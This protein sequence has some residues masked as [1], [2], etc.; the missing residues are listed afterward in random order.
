M[1]VVLSVFPTDVLGQQVKAT[2]GQT[3]EIPSETVPNPIDG[4]SAKG[5]DA[6]VIG[7]DA[8]IATT[9]VSIVVSA[10]TGGRI[11]LDG[12]S[13]S[14]RKT[15]TG[16]SLVKAYGVQADATSS[17][18]LQN[19][20]LEVTASGGSTYN[21]ATGINALGTITAENVN[22]TVSGNTTSAEAASAVRSLGSL[23][24][25]GGS[26]TATGAYT[27]GLFG[28]NGGSLTSSDTEISTNGS[29]S[30]GVYSNASDVGGSTITLTGG[31]ITTNGTNA[32]GL[33]GARQTKTVEANVAFITA[34]DVDIE[35]GG[36]GAH[37]IYAD[38]GSQISMTGGSAKTTGNATAAVRTQSY[39]E[40][41]SAAASVSLSDTEVTATGHAAKGV[42][43]EGGGV[44]YLN[45]GSVTTEGYEGFALS[46][47]SATAPEGMRSIIYAE[48]VTINTLVRAAHGAYAT[49][50]GLIEITG[51]SI[52]VQA[53][54][55][56]NSPGGWTAALY[57]TGAGSSI[58]GRNV[59]MATHK[60]WSY[61]VWAF[62]EGSVDV[63]GGSILTDGTS[64]H[65]LSAT[66]YGGVI[67]SEGTDII[68]L[69]DTASGAL[70]YGYGTDEDPDT[71]A[72]H[73]TGGTIA[74][75]GNQASGIQAENAGAVASSSATVKTYGA[76]SHG[77]VALNNGTVN[78]TGG[79]VYTYGAGSAGLVITDGGEINVS[80]TT[81]RS[82]DVAAGVLFG[83]EVEGRTAN[84]TFGEGADVSS[85]SGDLLT[86]VRFD[87]A[88]G[89]SGGVTLTL[90]SGATARGNI[91]DLYP[92]SGPKTGFLDIRVDEGAE[93]TANRLE[94]FR[95]LKVDG[96]L[97]GTQGL[98]IGTGSS[99]LGSGLV[100]RDVTMEG[101]T[102]SSSL[103]IRG[104]LT[105][106][107]SD[108]QQYDDIS[109]EG[110]EVG[111]GKQAVIS[112]TVTG[113]TVDSTQGSA[114]INEMG[115][116]STL[117]SGNWG[118]SVTNLNGGTIEAN[119]GNVTITNIQSGEVQSG[120]VVVSNTGGQTASGGEFT[121]GSGAAL[122]GNGEVAASTVINGSLNPGNS[123]GEIRFLS[124]LTLTLETTT[125]VEIASGSWFDQVYVDGNLLY[126]GAL[127]ITVNEGY[128]PKVGTTF[129]LFVLG[130]FA[131]WEG[132]FDSITFI[133]PGFA[134]TFDY[135]SGTL[136]VTQAV[137]EPG[138]IA[139]FVG[140]A[141]L[142]YLLRR[143]KKAA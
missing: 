105:L 54:E 50:G 10:A 44:A 134:G 40:T 14:N 91:E 125:N 59:D 121:V 99:L 139:L 13:I 79:S 126:A 66:G 108:R 85:A 87:D 53:K 73:V 123:P 116:G 9:T 12:G 115:S 77:A 124:D 21:A 51:G 80:Q 76:A 6:K 48:D 122:A 112:G 83:G 75:Y 33:Y 70:A 109:S 31:S 37:A 5:A 140:A 7:S 104:N 111:E 119:N 94:G 118:A 74:T 16:T 24:F 15:G 45:G 82:S 8:E 92:V 95:E 71:T 96:S 32:Y 19:L 36:A 4:V 17:V 62:H 3:V 58:V 113:G 130:E 114:E 90:L 132:A 72:V 68:T 34:T 131:T 60:Q 138:S 136:T 106:A 29:Y 49:N 28:V 30:I 23:T 120:T 20:S 27:Y 46:A 69:G 107:E 133:N 84:L 41:T 110:L 61:G 142:G 57:A 18:S 127:N 88:S 2:A 102:L 89:A 81:V 52:E 93:L 128:V 56:N 67:T 65:G 35:S 22:V 1:A 98:V 42:F 78:L 117:Q 26:V 38:R 63:T 86:V 11:E 137:P 39:N 47:D 103:V 55:E 135:A 143:R 141:G 97:R 101:G 64:A 25:T 43:A 129:G 100:Q